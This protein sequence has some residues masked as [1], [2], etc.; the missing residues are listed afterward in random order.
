MSSERNLWYVLLMN[1]KRRL[2][3]LSDTAD[4]VYA[5]LEQEAEPVTHWDL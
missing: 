2:E 5:W 3:P 4:I 1:L